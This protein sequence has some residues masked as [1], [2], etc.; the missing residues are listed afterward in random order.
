MSTSVRVAWRAQ[1]EAPAPNGRLRGEIRQMLSRRCRLR[2]ASGQS[3][4]G[5]S[6]QMSRSSLL[7]LLVAAVLF[8]SQALSAYATPGDAVGGL[9]QLPSPNDC[10]SDLP[11]TTCGTHISGGLGTAHGAALSPDGK[12]LYVASESG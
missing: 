10:I 8:A 3:V 2:T 12:N 1:P 6:R 9:L 7:L 5:T 11:A 4:S